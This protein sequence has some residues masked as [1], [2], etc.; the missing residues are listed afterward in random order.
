[1]FFINGVEWRIKFVPSGSEPLMR[2][3]GSITVGVT[4]NFTRTIYLDE[5][6][7]GR[8]LKKVI[9]HE[10]THAA[11]FSYGIKLNIDQEEIIA[12]LIATY[13]QEIINKTNSIFNRLNRKNRGL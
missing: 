8:R 1:M 11:M 4:D 3:D 7:Y 13:G 6:L 10:L 12:D 2:S 9:C 5:T